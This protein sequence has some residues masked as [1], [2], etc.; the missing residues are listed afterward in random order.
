MAVT[1]GW[2]RGVTRPAIIDEAADAAFAA[3]ARAMGLDPHDRWVGG[4]VDYEWSHLRPMLAT[5]GLAL[6]DRDVLEFGCNYGGSAIVMAALGGR[7]AGVDVDADAVA[8]AGLN[9]ARF[10]NSDIRLVALPPGASLPFADASFDFVLA[11]SVL[12]YVRPDLLPAAMAE[13]AR[14]TRPGG[15][16]LVTGTASRLAPREVHSRRWFAN[17]V[18]RWLVPG[19]QRGL[20]PV[21]LSRLAAAA[22]EDSDARDGGAAWLAARRAVRGGARA[23]AT[24]RAAAALARALGVSPGWFGPTISVM[25]RRR[26]G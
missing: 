13:L 14:V 9:A 12:E 25:L 3:K 1:T 4:Y 20:S 22:F 5:Y 2:K 8:L 15:H 7:V 24:L 11:N 16:L 23:S 6:A 18:P 10:G 26:G 17:Y 21:R 19:W